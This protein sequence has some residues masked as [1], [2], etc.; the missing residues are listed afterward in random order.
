[1]MRAIQKNSMSKFLAR[2]GILLLCLVFVAAM[3]TGAAEKQEKIQKQY[4]TKLKALKENDEES[5]LSL[6]KWCVKNDLTKEADQIYK[7]LM[8]KK[9]AKFLGESPT[10]AGYKAL[11]AWCKSKALKDLEQDVTLERLQLEFKEQKAKVAPDDVKGMQKLAEW[12]QKNNL[13]SETVETLKSLLVLQPDN[14]QVKAQLD[15]FLKKYWAKAPTGLLKKQKV[16][17]YDQETAWYH[18][19]VPKEHKDS[20]AGMPLIIFLHGGHHN[21]GTAENVVALAQVLPSFKNVIVLFPNHLKTWWSHPR[22]LTYVL[23][24]LAEVQLR[25]HVDPKRIYLMGASMGGNGTWGIGS[26]CPEIFAALAPMSGF[27][28]DFLGF[29]MDNLVKKPI[30]ILHG[31]QDTTVPIAGARQAFELLKQKGSTTVTMCEKDCP[32]QLPNEEIDK[33]AAWML[34]YE[35]GQEFDLKA[36]RARIEKMPVPGWLKQYEGN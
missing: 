34:K 32:H 1:M 24:T 15:Q 17:G 29:P 11:E 7:G 6:A 12:C 22:E 30:Y 2:F 18:I 10:I 19:S 28:A 5:C 20:D 26:F 16:P 31:T 13:I 3:P 36:I 4:Q 8:E 35:N 23:D 25:W 14:K 27:W 9:R 21:E 33:A